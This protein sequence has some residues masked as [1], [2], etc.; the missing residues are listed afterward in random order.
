MKKAFALLMVIILCLLANISINKVIS[1]NTDID[2][3]DLSCFTIEELILLKNK[4]EAEITSRESEASILENANIN[5][6]KDE[7]VF[8]D[9]S[10]GMD[11]VSAL[12]LLIQ[13]GYVRSYTTIKGPIDLLPWDFQWSDRYE[14]YNGAGF[15]VWGW[16]EE[17]IA[18]YTLSQIQTFYYYD[19]DEN[20]LNKEP[21]DSH[22]YFLQCFLDAVDYSYAESDLLEKLTNLYGKP[23][24]NYYQ[25][26]GNY[27]NRYIW[28][29]ANNTAVCLYHSHSASGSD[30]LK[31]FYGKTDSETQLKYVSEMVKNQN[32]I[33]EQQ[34]SDNYDGLQ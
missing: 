23:D 9:F 2:S 13:K 6:D 17:K 11:A 32:A 26:N 21:N 1:E 27:E 34:N 12:Q 5:F 18:G 25:K 30:L 33:L 3:F 20:G 31:L 4:I 7:I 10:W 8:N 19:Y 15:E 24:S 22:L 28:Y 14:S 16:S 29:G